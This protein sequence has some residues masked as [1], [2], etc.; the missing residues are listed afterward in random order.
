VYSILGDGSIDPSA[1]DSESPGTNPH[2][3]LADPS[4]QWAFVPVTNS[5]LI[6]QYSFDDATG[7]LTPNNPAS[8]D[9]GNVVGPRHMAFHPSKNILYVVN[10]H[11]DSVTTYDFDLQTGLLSAINTVS[12]LPMGADGS[13]NTCA[14]IHVTPDGAHLYASNRG[15]DSLAMFAL[16][17]ATGVPTVLGHAPTEA[18]PREFEITPDGRFVYSAGQASD[19]LAAYSVSVDGTLVPIEVYDVGAS[20]SWVLAVSVD[21]P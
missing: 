14:D 12:T 13:Q 17:A 6:A 10:E 7:A 11:A 16:D 19:T 4:N 15:H 9:T 1:V 8:I 20:P 3:I 18:V 5:D 2:S 21:A